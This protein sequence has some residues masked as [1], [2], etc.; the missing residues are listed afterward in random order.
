[1]RLA[2]LGSSPRRFLRQTVIAL[3]QRGNAGVVPAE[4]F[5]GGVVVVPVLPQTN[6]TPRNGNQQERT[7]RAEEPRS[8]PVQ[9]TKIRRAGPERIGD[10]FGG[11]EALG[12]L[13]LQATLDH[14]IPLRRNPC[15]DG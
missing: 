13:L 14:A 1:M 12:G 7:D 15:A 11:L 8:I 10:L 6:R 9:I 2:D 4:R 3:A 5:G